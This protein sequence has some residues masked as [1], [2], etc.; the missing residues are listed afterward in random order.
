MRKKALLM[1][2]TNVLAVDIPVNG[3]C[4]ALTK[5]FSTI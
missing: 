2:L 4:A 5:P 3:Q 1:R